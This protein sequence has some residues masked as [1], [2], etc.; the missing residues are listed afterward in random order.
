ME[1]DN[2]IALKNLGE[3]ITITL[4]KSLRAK[5]AAIRIKGKDIELVLPKGGNKNRALE[6]L[7]K[8]ET[9]IRSKLLNITEQNIK[10]HIKLP[11][12]GIS[13][14]IKYVNCEKEFYVKQDRKTIIVNSPQ[15][16][17]SKVLSHYL[18]QYALEEIKNLVS[19]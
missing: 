17:Y 15:Y 2:S 3:P 12:L 9:W 11:I 10:L 13:H 8:K 5:N 6:F 14:N 18:K 16:L 1:V 7:V 19:I 4:R